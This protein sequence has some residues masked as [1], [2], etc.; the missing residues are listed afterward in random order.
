MPL[1]TF[2]P[3]ALK[4]WVVVQ[5]GHS[6]Y[7]IDGEKVPLYPWLTTLLVMVSQQKCLMGQM[8]YIHQ[9]LHP[10]FSYLPIRLVK[11]ESGFIVRSVQTGLGRWT[12]VVAVISVDAYPFLG[13]LRPDQS[14][15]GYRN[16]CFMVAL[17]LLIVRRPNLEVATKRLLHQLVKILG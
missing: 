3:K 1:R 17:C 8:F 5:Q 15:W 13:F 11:T 10:I 7:L 4:C 14:P 2:F 16:R 9:F 6:S 12:L